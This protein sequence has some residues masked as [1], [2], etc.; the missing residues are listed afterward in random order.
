MNLDQRFKMSAVQRYYD[1][2]Y[3]GLNADAFGEKS[4]TNNESG[5]YLGAR[6]YPVNKI[7]ISAYYDQYNFQWLSYRA[8]APA[9]GNDFSGLLTY[10]PH[11]NMEVLFLYRRE[12]K[13][14]N[15]DEEQVAIRS[16]ENELNDRYRVQVTTKINDWFTL[17][18][19]L[20][21][22][23]YQ[24]G[25]NAMKLGYLFYQDF[26]FNTK[27]NKLNLKLRYALFDTDDYD[28]RIYAYENDI[29]YQFTVPAYSLRGSRVYGVVRYIVVKDLTLNV[30]ITQ[31]FQANKDHFG[32]GKDF[33][34]SDTKTELKSQLIYKF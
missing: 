5:I 24:L 7:S 12:L 15:G 8:D 30:K 19:R 17:R 13:E 18:T 31:T 2:K 34:N 21:W 25:N 20:E 1:P 16:L 11:H 3:Q 27:N 10:S 33:I 4:G 6:F 14:K 32:D 26:Y 22:K 29:R 28:S 9:K 23:N